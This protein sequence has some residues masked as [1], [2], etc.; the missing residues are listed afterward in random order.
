MTQTDKTESKKRAK[1]RHARRKKRKIGWATWFKWGL[2]AVVLAAMLGAGGYVYLLLNGDKLLRE[3]M[4]KLDMPEASIFYDAEGEEFYRFYRENRNLAKAEEVPEL[5]IQ[6]FIA[7]EDQRFY[8]HEGIDFWA[9]GRAL[10]T[11]IIHRSFVQGGSTITQ[12]LAKN[13]FLNADKTFLRKATEA[14]MAVALERRYDK[15]EIILMYLNTIFFGQGAYGVKSAAEVYFGK[16][17]LQTLELWE[18]ATLAAIPKAPSLY[19]PITDPEKSKEQRQVVLRLMEEQGYITREE[20]LAAAEVDY[21]R[22]AKAQAVPGHQAFVDYVLNEVTEKAGITEEQLL[23]GGYRIHTTLNRRAQEAVTATL[24]K[25]D[26]Y[27]DDKDTQKV[28]AGMVILD[29]KTGAI[30]AMFGGRDYVARGVNRALEK[31]QPGSAFK[32]I[33]V[34]A[35]ALETGEWSPYSTLVDRPLEYAGYKP[36]NYD[37]KYAGEISMIEAIRVSKNAAAVWLLNEIG[38][39]KGYDYARS[40][41]IALA[42]EDRNLA[43]ALGGLT[44]GASPLE[45]AQAYTPFANAGNFTEAYA[46]VSVED[47]NGRVIYEHA[48]RTRAVLSSQTAYEMTVMLKDAVDS[49]TGR[50]ARMDRDVAGKTGTTQ[51]GLDTVT[52]SNANRDLWFV[53]YTPEWTAAIWMGFPRTDE[54]HYLTVGSG[55]PAAMFAEAMTRA[56]QGTPPTRFARP[57]GAQNIVRPPQAVSDLAAV[58][59]DVE[60]A[61]YLT[62]TAVGDN[63][64]YRVY[65][66]AE[67]ETEFVHLIDTR[68]DLVR[69]LSVDLGKTYTYYVVVLDP[70]S[71]LTS[72][73]SNQA[74]VVIPDEDEYT[75]LPEVTAPEEP[76]LSGEEPQDGEPGAEEG[77]APDEGGDAGSGDVGPGNS[78][79]GGAGSGDAGEMPSE[80]DGGAG[81]DGA[82]TPATFGGE[83]GADAGGA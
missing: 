77:D 70:S 20:R 32:P 3:N 18:I 10:V 35:P 8:E 24:S 46:V 48:T 27:A 65:R 44:Y 71:G 4:A 55:T 54:Q 58:F 9:I 47:S 21:V 79:P 25:P 31:H 38:V 19:N 40:V 29:H 80:R 72:Q 49:G 43:I 52:N 12:Q 13:L 17:D 56:L 33:A 37:G 69:D 61:V 7:K 6:A 1:G 75:D 50:K 73:P 28:E 26:W 16:E 67:D 11:D 78:G 36:R 42:P 59:E 51:V 15:D 30:Q 74:E 2:A 82:L 45:M 41:G 66:K 60:R 22:P 23:I 81:D 62:W 83:E 39:D 76:G 64:T 53:G 14:S 63:K 5:L 34:Y 68:E 57:E